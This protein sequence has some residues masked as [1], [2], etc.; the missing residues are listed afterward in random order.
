MRL[1][2]IYLACLTLI[3][4]MRYLKVTAQLSESEQGGINLLTP[5]DTAAV[6]RL[7]QDA[8]HLK[9]T[10]P[11]SA[12][13]MY[14]LVIKK[15]ILIGY[16]QGIIKAYLAIA[17]Q[18][19]EKGQYE[20]ATRHLGV[21]Q[22][23][24]ILNND[25][26]N[27]S[28]TYNLQGA[29]YRLKGQMKEALETYI[30]G[31]E[32]GEQTGLPNLT[33][34]YGNTAALL[35]DLGD[36]KGIIYSDKAI[37]SARKHNDPDAL[38]T[39][40]MNRG[41]WYLHRKEYEMAFQYLDSAAATARDHD[42]SDQLVGTIKF[43]M[44]VYAQLDQPE[45]ILTLLPEALQQL[46]KPGLDPNAKFLIYIYTSKAYRLLKN[47][48]KAK[49][50]IRL[51]DALQG[52]ITPYT[53]V[54]LL[55]EQ[56]EW[57]LAQG[58]YKKAYLLHGKTHYLMDSL[59]G[60]A[61]AFKV[62]ELETQYR[63]AA[64]D[65]EIAQNRL[66]ILATQKKVTTKNNLA[67]SIGLAA[68][69]AILILSW[70][71]MY[72]NRKQKAEKEIERLKGMMEG[73]ENER[74]RMAHDLHDSVN[75]RLA[76][77]QS[78]LV[79]LQQQHPDLGQSSDFNRVTQTLAETSA[80]VRHIAHNLLPGDL[81]LK[82]LPMALQDFCTDLLKPHHIQVDVQVFG[83]F[84]LLDS[85]TALNVYRISQ[86]LLH[87]I[88]KHAEA[89]EVIVILGQRNGELSLLVEDNGVGI[90][91]EEGT[92]RGI[93]LSGLQERVLAQKG[94]LSIETRKG[95]GT[96]VHIVFPVPISVAD[97]KTAR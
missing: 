22:R 25:L 66:Q 94:T 17:A 15:S 41:N 58:Q 12:Y 43:K 29:L 59:S 71:Y 26:K 24:C 67:L 53:Y 36:Q 50:Y 5:E 76:V 16:K 2:F 23:Y 28:A 11:D 88:I 48:N 93:G 57:Y 35:I 6:N 8:V 56:A 96:T 44:S 20:E 13:V 3:I 89:T 70:L 65:R 49:Q 45:G 97:H 34:L 33:S 40:F 74:A 38:S 92:L 63:T 10:Y 87:N 75:S 4:Q 32:I 84:E 27:L 51:A 95:K 42:L 47:Y 31:I 77:T 39:A 61:L 72:R 62:T 52:F 1:N 9:K 78:Y 86:E 68:T 85:K 55:H 19:I 83:E 7:W 21:A 91:Q 46:K 37:Q 80:E 73:E 90:T 82:G 79:A 69:I 54:H 64:K 81:I 60:K 14:K 18:E 30:K